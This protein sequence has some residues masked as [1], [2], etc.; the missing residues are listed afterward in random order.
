MCLAVPCAT[1]SRIHRQLLCLPALWYY[2]PSGAIGSPESAIRRSPALPVDH[3]PPRLKISRHLSATDC[4]PRSLRVAAIAI[5][6]QKGVSTLSPNSFRLSKKQDLIRCHAPA[7]DLDW[8]PITAI[9]S[10]GSK[11]SSRSINIVSYSPFFAKRRNDSL[12]KLVLPMRRGAV[13]NV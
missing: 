3:S 9:A 8:A 12:T 11:T 13:S 6:R 2:H 4:R 7:A 10:A 1:N 5:L